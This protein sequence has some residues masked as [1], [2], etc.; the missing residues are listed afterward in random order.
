MKAAP[1]TPD[2][3]ISIRSYQ[4]L[5]DEWIRTIGVRYF[6]PLTNTAILAEETGEVARI[7]ARA[8]G[9]Q[10]FKEGESADMLA[11]E[12]ADLLWVLTAI[13]NQ[14]GIDLTEAVRRNIEKKTVRDSLRHVSNP[15][16][17]H[18]ESGNSTADPADDNES[19]LIL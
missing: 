5:V 12:L 7:M 1:T 3:S 13:A 18:R 19:P 16:L 6:S 4:S 15:K 2:G 17:G 14:T 11:D 8:Y 9:D 10:S